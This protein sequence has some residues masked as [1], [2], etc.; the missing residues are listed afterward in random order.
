MSLPESLCW[1]A[2]LPAFA[3]GT[4]ALLRSRPPGI[5]TLAIVTLC[6]GGVYTLLEGNVGTLYRHRV[7]FQL[8]AL[9]PIAAGLERLLRRRLSF[10]RTS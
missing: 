2:L 7:Q 10:F 5:A 4:A 6:L 3:V 8:L 1:Y 9:V